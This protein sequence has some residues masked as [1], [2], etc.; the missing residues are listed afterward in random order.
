MNANELKGR[1]TPL[2]QAWS[3]KVHYHRHN[4]IPEYAWP[5]RAHCGNYIEREDRELVTDDMESV[6]AD[7]RCKKCMRRRVD[8]NRAKLEEIEDLVRTHGES[9][10]VPVAALKY[11]IESRARWAG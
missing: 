7:K 10:T 6:P 9:G 8:P 11:I 3:G 1:V 2:K 4:P 5:V